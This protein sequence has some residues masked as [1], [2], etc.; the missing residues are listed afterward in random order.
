MGVRYTNLSINKDST[1]TR[2]GLVVSNNV[3]IFNAVK[4]EVEGEENV[5]E[6]YQLEVIPSPMLNTPQS[7]VLYGPEEPGENRLKL[8]IFYTESSVL[9]TRRLEETSSQECTFIDV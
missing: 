9:S 1:N 3:N 2:L 4:A 5:D 6:E 7:T 8:N